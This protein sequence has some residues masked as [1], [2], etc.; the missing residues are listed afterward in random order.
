MTTCEGV[1]VEAVQVLES[2]RTYA[3]PRA[4]IR[5]VLSHIIRLR[6]LR[7]AYKAAYVRALELYA[8]FSN[9]D[10]V[11]A[12]NVAHMERAGISTIISFD[13]DYDRISTV[14]RVEP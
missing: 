7:L 4:D 14:T 12:L 3:L 11:D 8:A 6:G 2:T 1:I 10:F 5:D 9:L 13:R